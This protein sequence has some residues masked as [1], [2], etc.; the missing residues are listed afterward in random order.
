MLALV[1]DLQSKSWLLNCHQKRNILINIE[2]FSYLA[3]KCLRDLIRVFIKFTGQT[4]DCNSNHFKQNI[5]SIN[6]WYSKFYQWWHKLL[7]RLAVLLQISLH[8]WMFI[9]KK[10]FLSII[11]CKIHVAINI[12]YFE[13][14][15]ILF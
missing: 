11:Y 1:V 4:Y 12:F 5:I 6:L 15:T 14:Y 7:K 9:T 8:S 2:E 13:T 3:Q 10:I